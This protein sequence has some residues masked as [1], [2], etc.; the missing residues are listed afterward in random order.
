MT[1]DWKA[2][3]QELDLESAY[4]DAHAHVQRRYRFARTLSDRQ[5]TGDLYDADRRL[6]IEVKGYVDDANVAAG[7]GQVLYYRTLEPERIE[8]VAVLVPYVP[9]ESI[10]A[11]F[12]EHGVGLMY[13]R[14]GVFVENWP[15]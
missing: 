4:L 9:S 3:S 11:L 10:H 14:D 7:M 12:R 5:R 1:A 15:D 6:L 8:R 13:A 2:S